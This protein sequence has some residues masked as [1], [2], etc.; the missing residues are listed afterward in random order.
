MLNLI[1]TR[2]RY[3]YLFYTIY[4]LQKCKTI[5]ASIKLPPLSEYQGLSFK[6]LKIS[7]T[8]CAYSYNKPKQT[9][10]WKSFIYAHFYFSG[11][12]V[13]ITAYW[14]SSCASKIVHKSQTSALPWH[15]HARR[16]REYIYT[17]HCSEYHECSQKYIKLAIFFVCTTFSLRK[18]CVDV[19]KFL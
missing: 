18:K 9:W 12:L 16:T 13:I 4:F 10:T 7:F 17:Y 14:L 8:N 3:A 15:G 2:Y 11:W 5:C 19:C 1:Y 6:L